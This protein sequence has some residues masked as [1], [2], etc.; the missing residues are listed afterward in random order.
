MHERGG[1]WVR[2]VRDETLR[3][4][5]ISSKRGA[6][7]V[8]PCALATLCPGKHKHKM[9]LKPSRYAS[10]SAVTRKV[11]EILDVIELVSLQ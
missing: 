4:S 11:N 10:G 3:A 1:R 9:T 6:Y 7:R 8:V 5:Q 2:E